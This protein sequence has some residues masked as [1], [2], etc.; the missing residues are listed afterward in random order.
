MGIRNTDGHDEKRPLL[1]LAEL[2]EQQPSGSKVHV[3][4]QGMAR[5]VKREEAGGGGGFGLAPT[6]TCKLV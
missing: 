2:L 3:A 6:V 1:I 4:S 5:R